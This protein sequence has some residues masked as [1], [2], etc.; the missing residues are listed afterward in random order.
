MVIQMK[1]SSAKIRETNQPESQIS[2]EA[3]RLMQHWSRIT[4][5]PLVEAVSAALIQ[6]Y[7]T[8]G[9]ALLQNIEKDRANWAANAARV[10]R[11]Q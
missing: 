8:T 9:N 5:Q 11:K 6:W 2:A 7:D 3:M 4:G 10:R 1:N